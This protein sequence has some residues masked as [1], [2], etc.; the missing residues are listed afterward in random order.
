MVQKNSLNKVVVIT[1]LTATG[2]SGLAVKF[3]KK[4]NGEIISADSVQ[5][6]KGLDIGSAKESLDTRNEIK[7]HLIDIKEATESY[8]VGEFIFDCDVAIKDI[9]SRN[10]LPIIVGGTGLYIKALLEGY[11]LGN[12]TANL[13]FRQEMQIL[14]ETKGKEHIWNL[15]NEI[16]P[17]KAKSV[18]F[19]NLKRVIRYLE[20]EKFGSNQESTQSILKDYDFIC[21]GVV[22][23]RETLYNRIN[24]RVDEMIEMGLEQEVR[25]LFE[26]GITRRSQSTTSIGYKEWFDY[27]DRVTDLKTTIDLIKQHSRNYAKRQLTFLKTINNIKLLT[28]NEAE[29]KIKEFL[30]DRN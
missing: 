26:S 19:N 23:D 16:N 8:N 30:D 25:S 1:G 12:T 14:A 22:E 2:K 9:L 3:A 17:E 11:S 18:H 20:I 6:Y 7:H 27:F 4:Y 15:L 28:L 21:V 29:Q 24:T 10:K 13:E 5:I